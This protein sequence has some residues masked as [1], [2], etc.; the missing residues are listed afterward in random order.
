M[1]NIWHQ[2]LSGL[3]YGPVLAEYRVALRPGGV[4]GISPCSTFDQAEFEFEGVRY[5]DAGKLGEGV[6]G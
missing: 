5:A 6:S 4:G 3:G 1:G 2:T